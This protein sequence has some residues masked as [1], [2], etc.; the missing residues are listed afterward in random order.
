MNLRTPPLGARRQAPS[1]H[2]G[3]MA[4]L[5]RELECNYHNISRYNV[6]SQSALDNIR[7]RKVTKKGRVQNALL[8]GRYILGCR[9]DGYVVRRQV[10]TCI[11]VPIPLERPFQRYL[12]HKKG[13]DVDRQK[14]TK[15]ASAF[16]LADVNQI[17]LNAL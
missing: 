2:L 5:L 17:L 9:R 11:R 1:C 3:G 14:P 13:T 7:V 4:L 12:G 10:A 6:L 16:L 15:I 8:H